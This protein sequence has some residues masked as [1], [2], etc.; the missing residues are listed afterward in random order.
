MKLEKKYKIEKATSDDFTRETL[1]QIA[2]QGNRLIATNGRI[3]A[4]VPVDREEKDEDALIPRLALMAAR[5]NTT[6][7]D[8]K[9]FKIAISPS[10]LLELCEAIGIQKGEGVIL[11]VSGDKTKD[12]IRVTPNSLVKPDQ[13]QA[14]GAIMPMRMSEMK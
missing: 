8:R 9:G 2:L 6:K 13:L 5:K 11:S 14:Y 4:V 1:N 3:V 12:P 7:E 10:L